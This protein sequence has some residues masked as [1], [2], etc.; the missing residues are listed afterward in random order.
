VYENVETL[1]VGAGLAGLACAGTLQRAGVECAVVEAADG[2]G[3][4]V[5]T[6]VVDGYRLDRGF[7]ILLTAYPELERHL[8]LEAL[9]L[10][11]FRPGAQVQ[12]SDRRVT[13]GDPIRR[14]RDLLTSALAPVGSVNDKLR[15]ARL[16][17]ELRAGD[18]RDAARTTDSTV[19]ARLAA[20]GFSEGIID[21]FFR[22]LIGGIQLDPELQGSARLFSLVLRML[23][24]GDAAVP[25]LG[26]GAIPAQLAARLDPA[27][28]RFGEAVDHVQGTNA[29]LAGGSVIRATNLVVATDG[30]TAARLLDLPVPGSRAAACIWFTMPSPPVAEPI[31]VLDGTGGPGPVRNVAPMS[32]VA[33]R[34]APDGRHVVAAAIPGPD[35]LGADLVAMTRRQLSAWFGPVAHE[36]DVARVDVIRHAQPDQPPPLTLRSPIGLGDGRYVCGDH[37]D[38]ASIQGALVSGRRTAEAILSRR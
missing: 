19:A 6:D 22:P 16:L 36:W 23:A 33:P 24:R 38:T 34:Y 32:V 12:L 3:G 10:C 8:D 1:I 26:M 17:L 20:L 2:P 21:R 25:A 9:D 4:R 5:R 11:A 15:L 37:R 7:Q 31:L 35:A 28:L 18:G 13:V 27:T 30:P 14:P 29:H